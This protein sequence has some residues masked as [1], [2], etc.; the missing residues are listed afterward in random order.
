MILGRSVIHWLIVLFIAVCV[1]F[2]AQYFIPLVF[3]LIG[4]HLPANI[5]NIFALLLA[6]GVIFGGYSY[7]ATP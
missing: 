4:L 2:L 6:A 7:R 3:N 5:V 1:F